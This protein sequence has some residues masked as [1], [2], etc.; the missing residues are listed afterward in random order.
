M[1]P[2][3]NVPGQPN[4]NIKQ[5]ID[6]SDERKA[7]DNI[8]DDKGDDKSGKNKTDNSDKNDKKGKEESE[9]D[10]KE[11]ETTE[12]EADEEQQDEIDEEED[13]DA[14]E[15]I[16]EEDSVYQALKK[17][18]KDIFKKVPELRHIIFRE[19]KY[20]E[21]FPT[22]EDATEAAEAVQT[23][24][25]Y[26]SDLMGG[27]SGPLLETLEKIDKKV[28]ENFVANFIPTLEKQSKD[29]YLQMIFP[30]IKKLCRA[31]AQSG[32]EN[33]KNS[34]YHLHNYVFG[35][36]KLDSEI[37]LKPK[38]KDEKEDNLSKRERDFEEKQY[39]SF[40][41]DVM[42]VGTARLEREIGRAFKNT[43]IS[44]LL[45]KSLISEIKQRVDESIQ[46]DTRHMGNINNLWSQARKEGYTSKSKE[47]IINT[48]LSRAKLLIPS[49]RQAVLGEAKL[50]SK[51]LIN[52]ERSEQKRA[53]RIPS[54]SSAVNRPSGKVDAKKI[55]W[56]K[57]DSERAMLDGNVPMKK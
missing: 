31:A 15:Q 53:T 39:R 5:G 21:I 27:N 26:Q 57:V 49:K 24:N 22:V 8:P 1:F 56:N 10:G 2:V 14:E 6:T 34:A 9:D 48:Y 36:I 11:T 25:Q 51:N 43:D 45:Q 30:E 16:S 40:A 23:F 52:D 17:T 20:T 33:L 4:S 13:E 42:D 54:S 46:K 37:G 47:R 29:L 3:A 28:L 32:D 7:F 38:E 41:T 19:Q 18:D 55:D 35:D 12:E 50:S 44:P